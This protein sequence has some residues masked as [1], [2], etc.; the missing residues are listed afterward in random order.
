MSGQSPFKNLRLHSIIIL[1]IV[2]L[3]IAPIVLSTFQVILLA[4]ALIN[5]ILA[6]SVGFLLGYIGLLS[7][8]QAAFYGLG[9]YMIGLVTVVLG[10]PFWAGLLLALIVPPAAGAGIGFLAAKSRGIYFAMMTLAAG[11]VL[12]RYFF[13]TT[14][15]VPGLGITGGANGITPIPVPVQPPDW[16]YY[17]YYSSVF[18]VLV[19]YLF[20]DKV[21][22]SS[23]GRALQGIRENELRMRFIG[24]NTYVYK[25]VAFSMAAFI[26]GVAG[27][28]NALLHQIA[29]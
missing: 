23:F 16:I 2:L 20:L 18:L 28:M 29:A 21:T 14:Y 8:G 9:A 25:V 15:N 26:A 27:M 13:Y 6:L 7:F 22:K 5:G 1:A 10:W 19:L 4:H 24:Y 3:I 17:V 11:E 12:H